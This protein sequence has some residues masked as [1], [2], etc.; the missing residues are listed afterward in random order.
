MLSV[1]SKSFYQAILFGV[2]TV[3]LGLIFSMIFSFL[4]PDL[5]ESCNE[6]DTNYVMEIGL[7][8]TGFILR[9]L[10]DTDLGK[11]YLNSSN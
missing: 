3:L 4:K 2:I 11:K 5:P 6:W 10:L 8:F 7:F 9:L 1:N